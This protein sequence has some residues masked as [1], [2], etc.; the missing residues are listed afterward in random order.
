MYRML[1][2]NHNK[3]L[4][5]ATILLITT[6]IASAEPF[7]GYY[8]SSLNVN[9][10]GSGSTASSNSDTL[11]PK[12]PRLCT[13]NGHTV[14]CSHRGL[15]S[16]PR[17]IPLETERL[18][19]QGNNITIIYETDFINLSKLR[20]L[21]LTD[22]Q[23]HTIEKDAF[24]DLTGLERL[25]LN[26]NKIKALP[27]NLLA[28]MT[29]LVRVDLSNNE[30]AAISKRMFKGVTALRSLQLDHNQIVC[31]DEQAFKNLHELEILTL[32]NNNI[33]TMPREMFSN[34]PRLRALRLSDNPFACDC[35]LSWL[36]K[37]LRSA[38]RLAPYTRCHSPSQLK[39]QNV[40]DLH[41]QEFKCSGLT[42][43][44]P[45]ECGGRSLCPH[46]CRCAEGIVDCRE[47]SLANVPLTLPEDTTEI[48][49]EQNY[50]TE[51]PPKAFTNHRRLRR[52]DL[53]NNNISRIAY[54]AFSGLKSLNSLV[55]YGNKIKELPAG[56]FKGLTSL[57]LL[58]LN[59]NE[60]SCIRKDSFK[61]LTSLSL[62]SLY[63]NNIQSLSNGTFESLKQ[64]QT[65]H[66][67][68][69][70]F[71]CDCNL[72]W[73]ADYLHKNPIETSGAKCE[74]PKKMHRRKIE[75]LRE[76]KLKCTEDLRSKYAADCRAEPLECPAVCHCERTTVDCS[77]RGLKEIPRDI[78]LYTTELLLNDNQLGR[79]KSD[80][81]FGRLPNLVKLDLR[82]NQ[83][84]GI[85]PRAF[86]G[87]FKIQEMLISENKM[88]EVHNKMFFGLHNLKT[89]SLFDNVISCVMPGSFDQLTSLS[90]L[91]LASNPFSCNC[92]LAWF[93]D[94][95]RKKQLGGTP[96][97]CASP[98]K[99]KDVAIKEMPHHEFKCTA[100]G[101]QGCLGDDY[102][103]ASCTCTGTVVRCS[104]NSLNE[105][106]RNIPSETTELYL[107]SNNISMIHSDRLKH[108]KS[109]TRLDLSNNRISILS[110]YTFTNLTKLSTLIISFNNLQ[111]VQRHALTGLK[112]L[113]V[114]SLH[115][116]QISMIPEGAF[117]DLQS[118]THI[119]LGSNPLYC[120]CS[121]KWLSEWVKL[122]YVEPGIARCAEPERMKDKL[123]LSTPANQF[124]CKEKVSNEILS[125]C[126]ACY[127]FP[128]KNNAEC[129]VK[130]E[131]QYECRCAP[132]Y[133]GVHCEN[134]IDACYGNPC[135]HGGKC[136]VLEEGRFSC[137]CAAG[138]KGA[139][140]EINID[141]CEEHKCQNNG[142]CVDGVQSY[143]CSCLAGFTGEYCETKIQFCGSDFNP[144]SNGAK[145]VD[146]YTHYTCECLAG[147]RGVNCT[148]NIDDCENHMCQ[149]GGTCVDGIDSYYCQ[150]PSEFTGKFCEGTP[151]VSMMYPQTSPCQNHECKFGVCF[152]PKPTSSDYIC[153]C[154]PGYTGK[155]CEYLTSLTFLHNNSF[156]EM[157][158][159][160]MK[161]EANVTIIFSTKEKNG[162]LVY[163]GNNN[164]E[165]F[166]VEL[167]NKRIRVSY[168]VGNQP[169]ST[170]YS[171]EEVTDGKYHKVELYAYKK[172]ITLRVDG[173]QAR[174]VINEGTKEYV[175]F[176][177]AMF[178][179]GVSPEAAQQAYNHY[180]LRNI[181][182]F[183]GCM[184]EV[185]INHKQVDFVNAARQQKVSPGCAL[186]D[187]HFDGDDNGESVQDQF[188]QEPPEDDSQEEISN[189]CDNHQCKRGGKC[190]PNN[191]GSYS[192]K[193]PKGYRGR[194]C[195]QG[196]VTTLMSQKMVEAYD[197]PYEK[198]TN[199]APRC[200]KIQT[201]EFY[202]ENGCRSK[203]QVKMGRCAGGCGSQC[204]TAKTTRQRKVRMECKNKKDYVKTLEIVRKC[205]CTKKCY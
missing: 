53:S 119:A 100:D 70:P 7:G 176:S 181:T 185:W 190:I 13:C 156:V 173:E 63:D 150:C 19:L 184:K 132:G 113:R 164:N 198:A 146:H 10:G 134:M 47:K 75:S 172:N 106:P 123:I 46:P 165:H 59:A 202:T 108:L 166:A 35:H 142:T 12:C 43:H 79:I 170:M 5:I 114:L 144:C 101:D 117:N 14:D 107:E 96:A 157:E 90:Q 145:C 161:P 91:N 197:E 65:L 23:L 57:Q 67:A 64:I 155:R 95:L 136:S 80:G 112:N 26:N 149:N 186:L 204:C 205:H 62:L 122:D 15:S 78:P 31:I 28:S 49:L 148:E 29:S 72:K 195:E 58:L 69:N 22:N 50:I 1:F 121:L 99:V 183:T 33:T 152:Q 130:P 109:L 93:S 74:A 25:R 162:V 16:V 199:A 118:I 192:C 182:S 125:K 37:F 193:C 135:R 20:I 175:K 36:S 82:R 71:I 42:E 51:I 110:N 41:D 27:D 104:R 154:N 55:L 115:G 83:I 147:F 76:E 97:R 111:C 126:D 92:H 89:L 201:K 94:W 128:C 56:V 196:E 189:P 6:I 105:I 138:Y 84:T 60:I 179:G 68:R 4:L 86:E 171:F 191:K 61:D 18:D 188:I 21:Q 87:A 139:R 160:R 39:G 45:I 203:Q 140:C 73:L 3:M 17:K 85:E 102:C 143:S 177:S 158:P 24:A 77:G 159:L 2:Y 54:D 81:L 88:S 66:L 200:R 174:S 52:I 194:Y 34:M 48:R 168:D 98:A 38:P 180:H 133:H 169:T 32:N 167:F 163:N 30:I 40:A 9:G 11:S 151:M 129:V 103:P 187:S 120:D 8:G 137:E 124:I 141:D 153:K 44:A 178:I 116:N 127:T 131:R